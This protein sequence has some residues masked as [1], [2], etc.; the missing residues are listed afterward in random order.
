VASE[1]ANKKG[2]YTAG[3]ISSQLSK[4]TDFCESYSRQTRFW[5]KKPSLEYLR[6]DILLIGG[7]VSREN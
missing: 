6:V 4:V 3:N 1:N 5:T 2:M 7:D